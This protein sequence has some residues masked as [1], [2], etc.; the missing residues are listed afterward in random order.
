MEETIY[1]IELAGHCNELTAWKI[2]K[3]VSGAILVDKTA[4]VSPSQIMIEEDG[5]FTVLPQAPSVM[6]GFEAPEVLKGN[7]TETSSV[8]SLAATLFYLVMGCQVMNGKGGTAQTESSKLPYMRRSLPLLSELVQRCLSFH[9]EQRP[10]LKEIN[11][12]TTQQ[13]E[14][15]L[16][17][18]KKG[19]RFQEKNYNGKQE[20]NGRQKPDFW[21]EPMMPED[22]NNLTD[23]KQ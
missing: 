19:P 16:E 5:R 4:T 1:A 20:G 9:P 22:R 7:C 13:L 14:L 18:V 17:T 2:L 12:L 21:P 23:T 11:S 3:E 6:E 10:S 8:W 15:C